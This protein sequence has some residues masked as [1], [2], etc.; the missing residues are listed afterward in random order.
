MMRRTGV[1]RSGDM[2]KLSTLYG[3]ESTEMHFC[4]CFEMNDFVRAIIPDALIK[5]D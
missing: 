5:G 2:T 1:S 4:A 3:Y